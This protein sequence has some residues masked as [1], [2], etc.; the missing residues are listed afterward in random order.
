MTR[1]KAHL[2]FLAALAAVTFA[3]ASP[4]RAQPA[5]PLPDIQRGT[6]ALHLN[7]IVTGI[8]APDYGFSPPG[9]LTR[10]SCCRSRRGGVSTWRLTFVTY[11]STVRSS[12]SSDLPPNL[13]FERTRSAVMVRFAARRW[14]RA[15]QLMSR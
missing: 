4:V 1:T 9:D 15:A 2:A 12:T 6:I 5:D 8:S 11:G 13:S 14:W 10:Q 3:A 7:P